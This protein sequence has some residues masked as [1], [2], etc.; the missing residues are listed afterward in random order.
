MI[1]FILFYFIN[2]KIKQFDKILI[3]YYINNPL[4]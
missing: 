3:L 4:I 1:E 2:L